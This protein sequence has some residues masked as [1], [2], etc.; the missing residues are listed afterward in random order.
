M[1]Q[2]WAALSPSMKVLWAVT[3]TA[4]L[5]FIIQS[6]ATFLG[7][8]SDS[9][10][11]DIDFDGV[12]SDVPDAIDAADGSHGMNL[13]TFRNLV[14]FCLGFG[15]TAVLLQ[16]S[17]PSTGLVM[18]LAVLVGVGLVALIMYLFKW[19]SSMQQTGTINVYKSAV[20]CQG[21]VYL[22]IPGER[23]GE[24]KVQITIAGAVREY[25]ALTDSDTLK[26]GTPIKV[27]EVINASTLLVEELNSLI[28]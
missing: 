9:I 4:S 16:K 13:L 19:V 18:V 27:V 25:A 8:D 20:G 15:W 22:T 3:L 14:N 28:I 21:T 2:W 5:I 7:A 12:D 26:T 10:D 17:V 1:A 24:G 6:I 23:K 11:S